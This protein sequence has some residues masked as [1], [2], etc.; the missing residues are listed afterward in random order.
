MESHWDQKINT[1]IQ[2]SADDS[3]LH[4][5]SFKV[6][7]LA[8]GTLAVITLKWALDIC[9]AHIFVYNEF[10]FASQNLIFVKGSPGT[11]APCRGCCADVVE[12]LTRSRKTGGRGDK[13]KAALLQTR[14]S[15][16]LEASNISR[17]LY[18]NL[19]FWF[20]W[21]SCNFTRPSRTSLI[22]LNTLTFLNMLA[23][24][25]HYVQEY[26]SLS[27][28]AG[29]VIIKRYQKWIQQLTSETQLDLIYN[30]HHYHHQHQHQHQHSF[31]SFSL[32]TSR[33]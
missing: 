1:E 8:E 19:F 6:R 5:V 24:K 28:Y 3:V 33:T 9:F 13:S 14:G 2:H 27:N 21:T 12:G 26:P 16:G 15:F 25:S 30:Q 23:R 7:F 10:V 31:T 22:F 20:S 32:T 11:G 18:D 29:K 17:H 4:H